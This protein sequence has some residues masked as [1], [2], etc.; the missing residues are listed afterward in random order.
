MCSIVQDAI[1]KFEN[2]DEKEKLA[3]DSL[4][5][6]MELAEQQKEAFY[7]KVT[8]S[9]VDTKKIPI[10]QILYSDYLVRCDV[11]SGTGNVGAIIKKSYKQFTS[12]AIADGIAEVLEGQHFEARDLVS[13]SKCRKRKSPLIA[14]S[15]ITT[16]ALGGIQRVDISLYAYQFSA[17][18]L[19]EITK[20][21]V[22]AVVIVSSVDADKVTEASIRVLVQNQF[23]ADKQQEVLDILLKAHREAM[24][25]Y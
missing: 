22:S 21:V 18:Q 13:P 20:N 25:K 4:N 23:P 14:H 7:L 19:T 2:Q 1:K 24:P 16:G 3:S 6:T 9:N 12:G 11:S 15:T 5:A 17:K 10:G 8:N